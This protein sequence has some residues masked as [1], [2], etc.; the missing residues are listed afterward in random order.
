LLTI[1]KQGKENYSMKA[2]IAENMSG[3]AIIIHCG[4]DETRVQHEESKVD[5][6]GFPLDEFDV[7][8]RL[9][10]AALDKLGEARPPEPTPEEREEQEKKISD[11]ELMQKAALGVIPFAV[12]PPR[13]LTPQEQR[14]AEEKR[15]QQMAAE[16]EP[17]PAEQQ[18]NAE[19]P[20]PDPLA[21]QT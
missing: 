17:S 12:A 14:Q 7:C 3:A 13:Q 1:N 15:A 2:E 21:G 8:T 5:E 16:S 19:Q 10:Q 18:Q 20:Q 9:L 4:P 11:A 6:N